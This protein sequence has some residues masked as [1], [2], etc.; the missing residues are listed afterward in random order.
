MIP[1]VVRIVLRYVRP[2]GLRGWFNEQKI[3]FDFKFVYDAKP[4]ELNVEE[5][6]VYFKGFKN[7]V[8]I[9][10][11]VVGFDDHE[12]LDVMMNN[13]KDLRICG[14]NKMVS[15]EKIP[16]CLKLENLELCDIDSLDEKMFYAP[17]VKKIF[18]INCGN[19]DIEKVL[20]G[21]M[22]GI[23]VRTV[24]CQSFYISSDDMCCIMKLPNLDTLIFDDCEK[25]NLSRDRGYKF[26]RLRRLEKRKSEIFIVEKYV[27]PRCKE[28]RE[29]VV[30]GWN[31]NVNLEVLY[32]CVNLRIVDIMCKDEKLDLDLSRFAHLRSFRFN[33][34]EM[35]GKK[36]KFMVDNL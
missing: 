34:K 27:I 7:I 8:L 11:N 12:T 16:D 3:S 17:Y 15:F 19:L 24:V 22:C 10:V 18:F 13:V 4:Y 9:G 25:N 30:D 1:D 29:L 5:L 20:S 28:L 14:R 36:I 6:E 32:E 21:E 23:N 2:E 35:L 33:G 31:C 26:S